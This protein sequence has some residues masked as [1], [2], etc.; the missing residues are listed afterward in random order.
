MYK[1]PIFATT[2]LELNDSVEGEHIETK[3]ERV[4]ATNEPIKDGAPIIYTPR[5]DGVNAGHNIRT[6]RWEVA[7]EAMDKVSKS[8]T[9]RR[10]SYLEEK[11]KNDGVAESIDGK[12]GNAPAA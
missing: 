12:A 4:I 6:D 7:I 5:K 10:D 11:E 3:M 8:Y 2:T 1:N 9:A